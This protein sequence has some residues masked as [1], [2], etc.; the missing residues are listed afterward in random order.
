MQ[1]LVHPRVQRVNQEHIIL[2]LEVVVVQPV[3]QGIIVQVAQ[4]IQNALLEHIFTHI[5][6]HPPPHAHH[7]HLDTTHLALGQTVVTGVIWLVMVLGL[8]EIVVM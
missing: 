2:R 8:V 5:M 3:N 7:V 1:L 4:V 6:V